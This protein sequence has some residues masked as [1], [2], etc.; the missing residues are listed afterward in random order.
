MNIQ[1][2]T[3]DYGPI[4]RSRVARNLIYKFESVRQINSIAQGHGFARWSAH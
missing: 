1:C 4:I 3:S 2:L